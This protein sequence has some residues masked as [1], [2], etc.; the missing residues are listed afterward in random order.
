[1]N[2]LSN[3]YCL[4][5]KDRHESVT[6]NEVSI[7]TVRGSP[8]HQAK[9]T[10]ENGRTWS[11]LLKATE[12]P[13]DFQASP[14]NEEQESSIEVFEKGAEIAVAE[15]EP[16]PEPIPEVIVEREPATHKSFDIPI[17]PQSKEPQEVSSVELDW[18]DEGGAIVSP[19]KPRPIRPSQRFGA[20]PTS[21]QR[22]AQGRQ[23]QRRFSEVR[24]ARPRFSEDESER[25]KKIGAFM[26]RSM[27]NSVGEEFVDYTERN[28]ERTQIPEQY[29]S[30]FEE[31]YLQG[32]IVALN[33]PQEDQ[34][35]TPPAEDLDGKTIA[36]I[37]GLGILAAW[38]ASQMK[39]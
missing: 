23:P 25:A 35:P 37:A 30:E 28:W 5:C 16:E 2:T 21:R 12:V 15:P 19:P 29:Y 36:G 22:Y 4:G 20:P 26:G 10:C 1:V 14:P 32:G 27:A 17:P 39:K 7:I 18:E 9:G 38:I 34:P 3:V 31:S 6:I 8:R 13:Q 33:T 11:K 24:P